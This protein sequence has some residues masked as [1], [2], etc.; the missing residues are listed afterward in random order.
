MQSVNLRRVS[1]PFHS[2]AAARV[3][4]PEGRSG[5][6]HTAWSWLP[7]FSVVSCGRWQVLCALRTSGTVAPAQQRAGA[8]FLHHWTKQAPFDHFA[9]FCQRAKCGLWRARE[10]RPTLASLHLQ[11]HAAEAVC[12]RLAAV[13]ARIDELDERID[14][15]GAAVPRICCTV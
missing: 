15:A 2:H 6:C 14:S 13:L 11:A 5:A 7:T 12:C 3:A 4:V 10:K 1:C 8:V 9:A